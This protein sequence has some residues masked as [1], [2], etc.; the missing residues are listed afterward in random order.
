MMPWDT[1]GLYEGVAHVMRARMKFETFFNDARFPFWK[2]GHF[3]LSPVPLNTILRSIRR[4]IKAS[5][6]VPIIMEL[7]V[8]RRLYGIIWEYELVRW[9]VA[10]AL[11]RL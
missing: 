4:S 3:L 10:R 6:V 9:N 5:S 2:L 7:S 11:C 8:H 1:I